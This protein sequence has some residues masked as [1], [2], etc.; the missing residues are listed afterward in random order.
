MAKKVLIQSIKNK[1]E[2]RNHIIPFTASYETYDHN[3]N[4]QINNRESPDYEKTIIYENRMKEFS[5]MIFKYTS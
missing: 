1:N 4:I 2:R 5:Q 3:L